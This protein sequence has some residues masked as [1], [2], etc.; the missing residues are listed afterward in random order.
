[1][2]LGGLRSWMKKMKIFLNS[3]LH[4][5]QLPEQENSISSK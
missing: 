1:M 5:K 3:L 2:E 4:I